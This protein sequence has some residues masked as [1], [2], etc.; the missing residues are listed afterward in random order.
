[1]QSMGGVP[2]LPPSN[3]ATLPAPPPP[4]KPPPPPPPHENNQPLYGSVPTKLAPV[5]PPQHKPGTY[6]YTI[7][8]AGNN[9][10]SSSTAVISQD[11]TS[12]VNADALKKL[13]EEER[14][15]DIQFQKWEEEIDK[16][17]RENINHP[18]KQAY[19]EYEQKFEACR[20]QLLE[21][22]QQMKQK[23]ASLLASGNT[24]I[25]KF[26]SNPP[27]LPPTPV[28]P[29]PQNT[30]HSNLQSKYQENTKNNYSSHYEIKSNQPGKNSPLNY[31]NS[32]VKDLEPQNQIQAN[33]TTRY[34][35]STNDYNNTTGNTNFLPTSNSVE[36]IPGLDLVPERDKSLAETSKVDL[37]VDDHNESNTTQARPKKPDYTT[38]SKGID[39][40]LGDEKIMNILSMVRV[41]N[42]PSS[43]INSTLCSNNNHNYTQ[44][45]QVKSLEENNYTQEYDNIREHYENDQ[46]YAESPSYHDDNAQHAYNQFHNQQYHNDQQY[47]SSPQCDQ[48]QQ[49][50]G[51]TQQFRNQQYGHKQQYENNQQYKIKQF[52]N[53]QQQHEIKQQYGNNQH[54]IN[55]QQNRNTQQYG[56]NQHYE[57]TQH[58]ENIFQQ[59][60]DQQFQNNQQ[61]Y[62]NKQPYFNKNSGQN[63]SIPQNQQIMNRFPPPN[64]VNDQSQ[65]QYYNKNSSFD[66]IHNNGPRFNNGPPPRNIGPPQRSA[67]PNLRPVIPLQRSAI[68]STR[69]PVPTPRHASL[70]FLR[71]GVPPA[72]PPLQDV[73]TRQNVGDNYT[74]FQERESVPKLPQVPKWAEEPMFAPSIVVEYEHKSLRLKGKKI[75]IGNFLHVPY[76]IL[77]LMTIPV[78]VL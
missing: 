48:Q 4:D 55:M 40:I 72:R 57:K 10:N 64:Q 5:P 15:F 69:P 34:D 43:S 70:P 66:G 2:P 6:N 7:P 46:E 24:N 53:N 42:A 11:V 23:K 16:W 44:N 32:N 29:P 1:M 22:R 45:N 12:S 58:F 49:Q 76:S 77:V 21:R 54:I 20:A 8:T 28:R 51:S 14:L 17:R 3:A 30:N 13:A 63:F 61:Q 26:Q 39:N 18:D 31:N 62:G 36:G 65:H 19:K 67:A 41:T 68:Q 59:Q 37:T 27:P 52:G 73:S 38:I 33:E 71:A 74:G 50:Q 56:N 35:I 25:A 60:N 9:I 78:I 47:G 75:I